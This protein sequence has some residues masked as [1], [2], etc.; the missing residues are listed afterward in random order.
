[1][2]QKYSSMLNHYSIFSNLY[3]R[4]GNVWKDVK[5]FTAHQAVSPDAYKELEI[6]IKQTYV[7]Q[8]SSKV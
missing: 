4:W 7:K 5:L 3:A 1:M 8:L 2:K 6:N